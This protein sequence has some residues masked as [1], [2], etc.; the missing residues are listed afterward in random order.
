MAARITI[1]RVID[2]ELKNLDSFKY[3]YFRINLSG[4]I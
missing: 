4:F 2:G 1:A 3:V